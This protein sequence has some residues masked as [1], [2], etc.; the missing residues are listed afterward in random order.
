MSIFVPSSCQIVGDTAVSHLAWSRRD[1][2]VALSAYS[3]DEND[4][5]TNQVL[6]AN[7]EV[8]NFTCTFLIFC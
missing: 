7:I 6:F 5:E 8:I 1:Q 4:K 3:I 2:I